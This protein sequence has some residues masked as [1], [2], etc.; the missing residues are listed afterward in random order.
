M[1]HPKCHQIAHAIMSPCHARVEVCDFTTC[2]DSDRHK[3]FVSK[4]SP[5]GFSD[6]VSQVAE[7]LESAQT[8]TGSLMPNSSSSL[9]K[10]ALFN[11][12]PSLAAH[13][14]AGQRVKS[15]ATDSACFSSPYHLIQLR[16]TR[17]NSRVIRQ[18][19]LH[20][21][22]ARCFFVNYDNSYSNSHH[23]H[24]LSCHLPP[25]YVLQT[26]TL[27]GIFVSWLVRQTSDHQTESRSP[28]RSLCTS[29][30]LLF[31][32]YLRGS[33][34]PQHTERS[35]HDLC[36]RTSEPIHHASLF[37]PQSIIH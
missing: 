34:Q 26:L 32:R 27:P 13:G 7:T 15:C 6:S 3:C 16:L 29:P 35:N 11:S 2:S 37:S 9:L 17:L 23:S 10:T 31:H 1:S 21:Y 14:R 5:P 4:G 20:L 19:K 25:E 18:P 8:S 36:I 22:H 24:A 30:L 33:V 12:L 28:G